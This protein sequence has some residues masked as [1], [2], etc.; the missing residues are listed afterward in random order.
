M[1]P[2]VGV[3]T[4]MITPAV[5]ISACAALILSTS[6]RL[7]RVVDRVRAL[8]DR[9][10]EMAHKEAG[11][12]GGTLLL[13]FESTLALRAIEHEMDFLWKLGQHHAPAPLL[14]RL[15][16]RRLWRRPWFRNK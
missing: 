2:E 16:P 4:S 12:F 10:E 5:L 7:G 13:G 6:V 14:E 3:L 1:L 9:Y 8:S 15:A 11:Q